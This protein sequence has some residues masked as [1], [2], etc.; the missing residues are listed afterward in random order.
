MR[1]RSRRLHPQF[2]HHGRDL[3]QRRVGRGGLPRRARARAVRRASG[4]A[5]LRLAAEALGVVIGTA[6]NAVDPDKVLVTGEGVDMVGLA[7][8]AVRR[9]LTAQLEH[10][11]PES[12]V[13]EL[14]PFSFSDYAR[15]AAVSAMRDLV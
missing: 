7:P 2:R 14:P 5:R 11:D 8:A 15:G 9:G 3:F 12:V 1:A 4:A 10:V 6:V 13:I